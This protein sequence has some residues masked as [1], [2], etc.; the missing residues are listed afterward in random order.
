MGIL[1]SPV[2]MLLACV[3]LIATKGF[4][5]TGELKRGMVMMWVGEDEGGMGVLCA[6]RRGY[7]IVGVEFWISFFY[8]VRM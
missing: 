8:V 2:T 5:S 6:C 7:V 1:V 3:S 4:G